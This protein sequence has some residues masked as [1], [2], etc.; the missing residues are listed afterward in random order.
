M[1][2]PAH[3]KN[4]PHAEISARKNLSFLYPYEKASVACLVERLTPIISNAW[5]AV[6]AKLWI[7]SENNDDD[8]DAKNHKNLMMAMMVFPITAE[9]TDIH[10]VCCFSFFMF[11]LYIIP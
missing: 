11:Q 10:H 5:F 2:T 9:N 6:S 7:D 3:I 8:H 4:I 1:V